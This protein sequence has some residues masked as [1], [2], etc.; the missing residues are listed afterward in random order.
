M[1]EFSFLDELHSFLWV[2]RWSSRRL[3]NYQ[4][5]AK[6]TKVA[7]PMCPLEETNIPT[8]PIH[9]SIHAL[10]HPTIDLSIHPII[11]NHY[12]FI[13]QSA[14]GLAIFLINYCWTKLKVYSLIWSEYSLWTI[15]WKKSK[16]WICIILFTLET[17]F[18]RT[19]LNIYQFTNKIQYH[20]SQ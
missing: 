1:T 3:I 14:L 15:V 6:M 11:S 5:D 2:Q 10:F 19:G 13:K 20:W 16:Q 9:P 4:R 18:D 8:V 17:K 7:G 12:C